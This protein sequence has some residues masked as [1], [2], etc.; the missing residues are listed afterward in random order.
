[1]INL[2]IDLSDEQIDITEYGGMVL[3]DFD[4]EIEVTLSLEQV[5]KVADCARKYEGQ[6][7][8]KELEED[9]MKLQVENEKLRDLVEDHEEYEDHIR[10]KNQE[11][12]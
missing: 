8:Y 12:F 2:K 3:K 7:T 5:D 11:L 1:M 4:R 6:K 9:N 10:E